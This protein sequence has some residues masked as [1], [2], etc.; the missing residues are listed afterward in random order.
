MTLLTI[1]HGTYNN[2]DRF[3]KTFNSIIKKLGDYPNIEFLILD[4]SDNDVSE[5]FV[6]KNQS[7]QIKYIKG[8]KKSIDHAYIELIKEASGEYVWWF[9]DDLFFENSISKVLEILKEEPDFVWMNSIGSEKTLNHKGSNQLNGSEVIEQ[10]GDLLT[11]LSSILWK[12]SFIYPHLDV[13]KVFFGNA[14][15]FC[16][17]QIE[18]LSKEGK[19]LYI[20]DPIF[21][22]ETDR[23]FSNLWYDPFEV[24]TFHY[25]NLLEFFYSKK[26]LMKSL[27]NEKKKRGNQIFKGVLYY[28]FNLLNYG[29]GKTSFK[30]FFQIYFSWPIFWVFL[31]LT[32]ILYLR[33]KIYFLFKKNNSINVNNKSKLVKINNS[34]QS[35]IKNLFQCI[36][37]NKTNYTFSPNVIKCLN[38]KSEY[39]V[40]NNII[41]T[42]RFEDTFYEGKYQGHIKFIPKEK[43]IIDNCILW[44]INSGYL[45]HTKKHAQ[46]NSNILEL[47]CGSGVSYF[48]TFNTVGMD[49][50]LK[51]MENNKVNYKFFLKANIYN[52]IPLK[53][54][55]M[56]L[57]VSSFFWE[58]IGLDKKDKCIKEIY[59][60]LKPG[61]KVIFLFDVETQNP[62]INWFKKNNLEKY[63]KFFINNDK[64]VGY[65]SIV[66]NNLKFTKQGFDILTLLGCEKTIFQSWSTFYKLA[67][68]YPITEKIHYFFSINSLR[69]LFY[70]YTFFLRILDETIGKIL[71]NSWARTV[72]LV[73]KK[74]HY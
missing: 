7:S 22:S 63:N 34:K 46:E 73:L 1:A 37:C 30:R 53:S 15:G 49:L 11:F 2:F 6:K 25:F 28:K 58:H 50:S 35:T 44:T 18:A 38:C 60:V 12:K 62:L 47:G 33:M 39:E 65:E 70:P 13:G 9:G 68:F 5:I 74:K 4:D 51:S 66:D 43:S 26:N 29:L 67:K 20:E 54:E 27:V 10:I 61:G 8:V 48:G 71:P 55:S 56:D 45:W 23:D 69:F 64:H 16:Y 72:L 59:R 21:N 14:I 32:L 24:F 57:I 40:K 19:F 52:K 31:P 41:K 17:P 3:E 42:D 36:I